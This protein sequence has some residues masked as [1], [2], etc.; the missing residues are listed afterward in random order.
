M[1]NARTLR[2]FTL[3]ELM[4]VVAILGILASIAYPSYMEYVKRSNRAEAIALVMEDAHYMERYFTA[5]NTYAGATLPQTKVPQN[6]TTRFTLGFSGTPDATSY[7]LQATPAS[8]YSDATCGTLT[9]NQAGV[10]TK[11]GTGALAECW[12]N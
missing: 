1:N 12:R 10:Q 5:Q 11:S 2:G 7:T 6:G 4:I 9:V 8:G 3:V